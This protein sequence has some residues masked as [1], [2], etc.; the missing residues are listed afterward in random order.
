MIFRNLSNA[1]AQLGELSAGLLDVDASVLQLKNQLAAYT[2]EAA[3]VEIDLNK[4]QGTLATAE[5]LISK[6]TEEYHRWQKQVFYHHND[7]NDS[8]IFF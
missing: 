4:A 5:G 1:E 3:E 2:K 7:F 6:L 8:I